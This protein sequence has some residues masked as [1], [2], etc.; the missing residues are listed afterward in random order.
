LILAAALGWG[1]PLFAQ[2]PSLR[3]SVLSAES[4]E[5]I[6]F[7]IVELIPGARRLAD[8]SGRFHLS[9]RAG[10]YRL[11]VRQ[12]G[13]APFDSTITLPTAATHVVVR[14]MRIGITLP[15][16]TVTGSTECRSPGAPDRTVTPVLASVFDQVVAN[17][18]RMRLLAQTYPHEM[19]F[20]RTLTDTDL[21][22][23]L[24]ES[25]IEDTVPGFSTAEW[26]YRPGRAVTRAANDRDFF[27]NPMNPRSFANQQLVRLPSL[28]DFADSIFV[29]NHCFD[30]V[31]RD[32]IDGGTFVRVDFRPAV[33][34]KTADVKGSAYLDS[35]T[36]MIRYTV[37]QL[38]RPERAVR[39]MQSLVATSRFREAAPSIVVTDWI[40]S[41]TRMGGSPPLLR[42]EHRRLVDVHFLKRPPL[43]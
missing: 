16:I 6:R 32:T 2:Q 39:R 22:G 14:L 15:A 37:V 42:T 26:T 30:L 41:V 23:N 43:H 18:R 38:T 28:E 40:R 11:V 17:A 8:D 4:D 31:G 35:S 20:A 21:S 9:A 25:P 27:G 10:T 24:I 7:S 5:P 34:I 29:A 13:F 1:A 33:S 19:Q 36:A 12:I 3:G